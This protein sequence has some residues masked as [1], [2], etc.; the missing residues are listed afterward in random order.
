MIRKA[1]QILAFLLFLSPLVYP[2]ISGSYT[3]YTYQTD[4]SPPI[5]PTK[6]NL[7]C[8]FFYRDGNTCNILTKI[9]D[10]SKDSV[11][12][13]IIKRLYSDENQDWVRFWNSRLP[14]KDYYENATIEELNISD[15]Q[16]YSNNSL[17]NTWIRLI[18]IYPSVYSEEGGFYYVPNQALILGASNV[19]FVVPDP[20]E[21][22]LCKQ[23]YDIQGYDVAQKSI[24]SG[25]ESESQIMPFSTTLD[26]GEIANLTYALFVNGTY[27]Q[28]LWKWQNTTE[29]DGA[30]CTIT[31]SCELNIS[32][33]T[34]DSLNLSV[35]VPL[36]RFSNEFSYNNQMAVPQKGLQGEL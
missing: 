6:T 18:N 30:N 17:Q 25:F 34:V 23:E 31:Q 10:D 29:C 27:S 9:P 22:D 7:S 32:N 2:I 1:I 26:N 21:A 35:Q 16:Y 15:G 28:K 13:G 5:E 11:L 4:Y 3:D 33:N 19:D 36:K 24:I 20:Q 12:L 14:I 8:T